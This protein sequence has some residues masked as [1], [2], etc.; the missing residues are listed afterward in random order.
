MREM[1]RSFSLC[2]LV[3]GVL[4]SAWVLSSQN[5]HKFT[6]KDCIICHTK[7]NGG[8]N[9]LCSDV[10]E[11]CATCHPTKRNYQ[12]HP[13]DIVPKTHL[14]GD[15][16]LVE[17]LFTC[18]SC[19]DVHQGK[20]KAGR[21]AAY[22]LRRNV[23]GKPFCLICH[24]VDD[25]GHLFMGTT[26]SGAFKVNDNRGRID[27]TTLLC[28]ECHD[29]RIDSMDKQLGAGS[30]NHFSSRLEHPIGSDYRQKYNKQPKAFTPPALLN[31]KIQMFDGKIG[32]GT[33]HD[34]FSGQRYMLAMNNQ[35]SRLCFSCHLK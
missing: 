1:I 15:I 8:R 24:D 4:I 32:C 3:A 14:P 20:R 27:A 26:H 31:P 34:R 23:S 2:A 30:W 9:N 28:I 22:F 13:T 19:H 25:K 16:L 5:G 29:D 33:C 21:E 11:A 7:E 35:G 18:V 6:P 17:G 10:T 12:A